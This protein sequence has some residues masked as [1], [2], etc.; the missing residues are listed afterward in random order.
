MLPQMGV[1]PPLLLEGNLGMWR[2]CPSVHDPSVFCPEI[3]ECHFPP[4]VP[5]LGG[6]VP[7]E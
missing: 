4:L 6:V 1:S 7:E 2:G 3:Q 5:N